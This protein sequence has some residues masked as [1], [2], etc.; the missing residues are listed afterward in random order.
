MIKSQTISTVVS[1]LNLS[2]EE[3]TVVIYVSERE[4]PANSYCK[5]L[6]SREHQWFQNLGKIK[7]SR[8]SRRL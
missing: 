7:I 1:T 4:I 8:Y 3:T 6:I 2:G 5:D